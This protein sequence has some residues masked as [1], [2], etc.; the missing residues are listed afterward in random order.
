VPITHCRLVQEVVTEKIPVTTWHCVP[1]NGHQ[2][3]SHPGQRDGPGDVLPAGDQDGRDE[4]AGLGRASGGPSAVGPANESR[5][6]PIPEHRLGGWGGVF[7]RPGVVGVHRPGRR[8]RRPSHPSRRTPGGSQRLSQTE[9]QKDRRQRTKD[10][11]QRTKDETICG[12]RG[13]RLF[14]LRQPP[15]VLCLLPFASAFSDSPAEDFP[16]RLSELEARP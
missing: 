9:G 8:R 14:C 5:L 11:R 12:D 3:D 16:D 10:K 7:R 13:T 2:E 15:S 6:V 1:E 4:P